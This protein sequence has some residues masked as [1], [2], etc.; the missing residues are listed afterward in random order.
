MIGLDTNILV[1][2]ITEDDLAQSRRVRQVFETV[3]S[4]ENPGFVSL[5]VLV[6]TVWVLESGY[7]L[8]AEQIAFA[9]ERILQS[10]VLLVQNEGEAFRALIMMRQRSADFA[11]AL[12]CELALQAG[13]S[14][15]LTFDRKAVRLPGFQLL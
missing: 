14:R 7:G 10:E 4:T 15:T 8:S 6:E 12:L 13:C 11:D 1:R 3:L 9:V 5:V 2:Y